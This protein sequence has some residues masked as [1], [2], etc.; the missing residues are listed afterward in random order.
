MSESHDN[1]SYAEAL[2]SVPSDPETVCSPGLSDNSPWNE[3]DGDPDVVSWDGPND[4]ANPRNWPRRKK[5]GNIV[6][7]SLMVFVVPLASSMF[8][9]GID[10]VMLEFHSDDQLIAA[11]VVSVFVLGFAFGPIMLAPL[12]EV[13]GRLKLYWIC[14]LLFF[15]FSIACA[16][17]QTMG[18]LIAFR[19]LC[20]FFGGLPLACGGGT[21]TDVMDQEERGFAMAIFGAGPMMGPVA[22]PII[23]GFL[24]QAKGWRW[25]FWLLAI[26]SGVCAIATFVLMSETYAPVILQKKVD[27]LKKETGN[28]NLHSALDSGMTPSVAIKHSLLRPLK[29]LMF[30]PA[31]LGLA[32][33]QA[34]YFGC[35]YLIFTTFTMVYDEV[36]HWSPGLQ[37]LSFIPMGLGSVIGTIIFGVASD[38]IL[39]WKASQNGG[40]MK[41][42]Y[43]LYLLMPTAFGIPIGLFWYGWAAEEHTHWV[44]PI[45]GTAFIGVGF[46]FSMVTIISYVMDAYTEYSASAVASVAVLRSLFGGILPLAGRQMYVTM[47]YGWGSSLLGFI[48]VALLPVP[49]VFYYYGERLRTRYPVKLR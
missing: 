9:P 2:D 37:G 35:L 41:P 24:S 48:S 20:G 39:K 42:E 32:L 18:Q 21:I 5:I 17:A 30:S 34:F 19:F 4:P 6:M 14:D 45:L 22:G 44:V 11:F 10:Q 27:R 12:S 40:V 47:G 1:Q 23:G 38:R 16:K 33:F 46:F 15:A 8:A 36:Y 3:K 29:L 49:F 13:Y 7:V 26:L 43:R 28:Q 31:V 25:V